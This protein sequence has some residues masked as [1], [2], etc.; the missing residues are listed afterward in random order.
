MPTELGWKPRTTEMQA[1]ERQE[2][3]RK[4]MEAAGV[5]SDS[6]LSAIGM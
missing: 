3:T 6:M 1:S 5:A 4:L 2:Y